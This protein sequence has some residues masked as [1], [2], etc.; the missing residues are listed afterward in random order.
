MDVVFTYL[1]P[2]ALLAVLVTLGF[3]ALFRGGD[4]GR[5]YSNRLMRLRVLTQAIA[6]AILAAALW[7]R[8][9]AG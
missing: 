9:Q 5:S 2:A 4:F 6:V 1:I 3:Y 7:W 8:Q